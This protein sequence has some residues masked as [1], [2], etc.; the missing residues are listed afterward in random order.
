MRNVMATWANLGNISS[1]NEPVNH[2]DK[3]CD[4]GT[5][6]CNILCQARLWGGAKLREHPG[7]VSS[8]EKDIMNTHSKLLKYTE[9]IQNEKE[10]RGFPPR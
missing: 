8:K 3:M 6:S 10:G 5:Y 2:L 1:K 9:K 4:A 7:S